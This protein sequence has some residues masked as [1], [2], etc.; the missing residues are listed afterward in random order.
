[1]KRSVKTT[2]IARTFH[3]PAN[4]LVQKTP[5][6]RAKVKP[7]KKEASGKTLSDLPQEGA[8]SGGRQSLQAFQNWRNKRGLSKLKKPIIKKKGS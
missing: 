6:A 2:P 7:E 3:M 1:M 4:R 5:A 8:Q